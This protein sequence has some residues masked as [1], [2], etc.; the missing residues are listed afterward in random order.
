MS[1]KT[2]AE[3]NYNSILDVKEYLGLNTEIILSS[4]LEK[5]NTL[6]GQEKVIHINK[7]LHSDTYYNAIGGTELY[8]KASFDQFGLKLLFLKMSDLK[9]GQFQNDFVPGLS[10]IDA[11]MFNCINDIKQLLKQFT[12]VEAE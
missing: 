12:L 6:K 11:L 10:I 9:Y 4:E 3:L 1:S 8:D 7:L 5:D 2:I